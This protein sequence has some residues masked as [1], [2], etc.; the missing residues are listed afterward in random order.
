[1]GKPRPVTDE[2]WAVAF[3]TTKIRLSDKIK[4]LI[5]KLKQAR[6]EGMEK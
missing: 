6:E 3:L 2:D 4:M 1:M 5:E